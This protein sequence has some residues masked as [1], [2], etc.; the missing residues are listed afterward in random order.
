M[1]Q[2]YIDNQEVALPEDFTFEL[3]RENPFFTKGGAFTLD[4]SLNMDIPSNAKLYRHL[5]RFAASSVFSNR[6][7]RLVVDGRT[8]LSG[9]EIILE[10]NEL[11]ASIQLASGNSELNFLVGADV[12]MNTLDLGD[13]PFIDTETAIK[14]RSGTYPEYNYICAPAKAMS[15]A[16]TIF[17]NNIRPEK[18]RYLKGL[19]LHYYHNEGNEEIRAMPYLNYIIER[20]IISLGY[21]I[22]HNSIKNTVYNRLFIVHANNSKHYSDLM[23][24]KTVADFLTE[25]EELFDVLFIVNENKSVDILFRHEYYKQAV[26]LTP[27]LISEQFERKYLNPDEQPPSH[28]TSNIRYDFEDTKE[29]KEV[30]IDPKIRQMLN[31]K[32]CANLAEINACLTTM[33]RENILKS[34]F[35][36][37]S[38]GQEFIWKKGEK[39]DVKLCPVN[40]FKRITGY[41]GDGIEIEIVPVDMEIL[42]VTCCKLSSEP[43]YEG[44][45][46]IPVISNYIG[47]SEDSITAEEAIQ[48]KVEKEQ[49]ISKLTVA[50]APSF[51]LPYYITPLGKEG[52]RHYKSYTFT[53]TTTHYNIPWRTDQYKLIDRSRATMAFNSDGNGLYELIYSKNPIIE[54]GQEITIHPI[55][56]RIIPSPT[57]IF[58]VNGKKCVCKDIHFKITPTG[59]DPEYQATLY[60]MQ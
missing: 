18:L 58:I 9:T 40:T 49:K 35:I 47:N 48:G 56:D 30:D 16:N 32:T 6:P 39:N 29:S 17:I 28:N 13:I 31:E 59:F 54:T 24:D 50:F 53:N 34:I 60:A 42:Y 26:T 2:L 11:S 46:Q 33:D 14:S 22:G 20:C 55:L 44:Y 1:T 37:Q 7:A 52:D 10:V 23:P 45:L 43:E 25:V 12:K 8:V 41:S 21:F 3:I 57:N 4:I 5:N 27:I 36:D 38:T 51:D 19:L 15:G